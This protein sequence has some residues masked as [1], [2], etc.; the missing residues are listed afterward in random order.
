ML[1]ARGIGASHDPLLSLKPVGKIS[2]DSVAGVHVT[3]LSERVTVCLF[4]NVPAAKVESRSN[5]A[6]QVWRSI[7]SCG[8]NV[9]GIAGLES[10][11]R[12]ALYGPYL[13]PNLQARVRHGRNAVPPCLASDSCALRGVNA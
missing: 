13:R 8:G 2:K 6:L 4:V 9:W 7:V 12:L 11:G 5:D 1:Q 3:V 10:H